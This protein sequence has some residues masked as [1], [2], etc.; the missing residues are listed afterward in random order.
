MRARIRRWEVVRLGPAGRE[1]KN[2]LRVFA[3]R[4]AAGR[5]QLHIAI[6]DVGGVRHR[7]VRIE[8]RGQAFAHLRLV[9][10]VN[11]PGI[12]GAGGQRI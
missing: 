3:A 2:A 10:S 12:G 6:H 4:T 7:L 5:G 1:W 9:K 8:E 11:P